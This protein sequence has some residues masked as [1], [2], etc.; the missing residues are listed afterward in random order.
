MFVPHGRTWG[1]SSTEYRRTSNAT[2]TESKDASV[3]RRGRSFDPILTKTVLRFQR[4]QR[5]EETGKT[6]IH[7]SE[8]G[9]AAAYPT[10]R[11]EEESKQKPHP[12]TNRKGCGTQNCQ[13]MKA[14]H[15]PGRRHVIRALADCKRLRLRTFL[16][17]RIG[18]GMAFMRCGGLGSVPSPTRSGGDFGRDFSA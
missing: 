3:S 8:C 1:L 2:V 9:Y 11:D 13:R 4:L 18:F 16:R 15:P 5:G 12:C 14:C 10:W 6:G 17:G 7:A